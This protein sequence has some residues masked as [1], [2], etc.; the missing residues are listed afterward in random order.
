MKHWL[1]VVVA[2]R[3]KQDHAIRLAIAETQF[4]QL[5]CDCHG[6]VNATHV[7]YQTT[8]DKEPYFIVGRNRQCRVAIR[9]RRRV[10]HETGM[11]TTRKERSFRVA[12]RIA[13]V[14]KRGGDTVTAKVQPASVSAVGRDKLSGV[15]TTRPAKIKPAEETLRCADAV[16]RIG[17]TA[18][19]VIV[20]MRSTVR[21]VQTVV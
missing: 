19:V 17:G 1:L 6:A 3:D 4:I 21:L 14:G 8:V 18:R 13:G 2:L 15:C 11:H 5:Q 16:H 12:S 10:I 7:Q 9:R 20:T